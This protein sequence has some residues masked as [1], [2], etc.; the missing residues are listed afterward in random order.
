MVILNMKFFQ[1]FYYVFF[2]SL[3]S[4]FGQG[5]QFNNYDR[6]LNLFHNN[7]YQNSIA[8]LRLVSD[9]IEKQTSLVEYQ[10]LLAA[11]RSNQPG[12]DK[13]L[14]YFLEKYPLNTLGNR[15]PFDLANYYFE[16]QKYSYALKWYKN[17]KEDMV[18]KRLRNKFNFNKGYSLFYVKRYR[19]AR[20]YFKKV[21]DVAEYESDAHYYLGHISYQLDDYEN[22]EG[23]FQKSNKGLFQNDL[24]YF[25]VDM[26]FKLARFEKAISLGLDIIEESDNSMKSELSKIIGESYFNLSDYQNALLYL[27]NYKGKKGRLTNED[28]YQLGYAYYNEKNYVEAINQFNKIIGES[29]S[30][31]QNAY[32]HL[33]DS[34]LKK[35]RKLEALNA[36]KIASE[37]KFDIKISEDALLH[38]SKLSYDIGNSFETPQKVML[39]FMDLYPKNKNFNDIEKLLVSSYTEEGNYDE[40]LSIL[41]SGIDYKDNITLQ[42]VFYLKGLDYFKYG[43]YSSAQLLFSRSVKIDKSQ[44]I[45]SKSYYWLA[46]SLFESD[47]YSASI[48]AYQSYFKTVNQNNFDLN[49]KYWYELA[50]CYFKLKDYPKSIEYFNE[51]LKNKEALNS[52][53]LRDT[54]LRLADSYFANSNYWPALETYNL[55]ISLSKNDKSYYS[56]FQKALSYGFLE[57]YDQKIDVLKNLSSNEKKHYLVDKALFEL[58]QTYSQ[59]KEYNKAINVYEDLIQRFPKRNYTGKAMLNKGL[60]LFNLENLDESEN[61]LK[62]VVEKYRNDRI[63]SQA[64]NT[65]KE[66]AIEQ[67]SVSEFSDWLILQ[68]I[69]LFTEG[70]LASSSFEAAE[71][72]YYEKK[73]KQAKKQIEEFIL[74]YPAYPE[75]TT[76]KYYLAD[77]FFKDND[78][79]NALNV[80]NQILS[81]PFNEFTERSNLNAVLASQNLGLSEQLVPLLL[82]LIEISTYEENIKFARYSLMKAYYDLDKYSDSK[83]LA[84]EILSEENLDSTIRWDALEISAY[85]LIKL[86][87]SLGAAKMFYELEKSPK[88][89]LASKAKYFRAYTLHKS[90][91]YKQSNKVI[92]ELSKIYGDTK[93]WGPKSILLMAKNFNRINDDFQ[94]IYLLESLIDNFENYPSIVDEARRELEKIK[95]LASNNNSSMKEIN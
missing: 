88:I 39:R 11:L 47:A 10:I 78:W 7:A 22:A 41:D 16:N 26:N 60:I 48:K 62:V 65:L 93:E 58:G 8:S 66:I 89:L 56:E 63:T 1:S 34:Y 38:Y 27:K 87:D 42:K 53:Y 28:Y 95:N 25:Q 2:L 76:L 44:N 15:L 4:L 49:D 92:S 43:N 50:Y 54:Y 83:L 13:Q 55:A 23:E 85:S 32:Y 80:Y 5:F 64:L 33:G 17:L 70:D 18:S 94:A 57:K 46:Q 81:L 9:G 74:R 51:Q 82:N 12:A 73:Y 71:K 86:K 67:G 90:G 52:S 61:I 21:Q 19:T 75:V 45:T 24:A 20:P 36:F 69:D 6:A 14:P 77:I 91:D 84:N 29:N 37:M 59:I 30:L 68:K 31:A 40:A 35:N 3:C 79:E 72:F